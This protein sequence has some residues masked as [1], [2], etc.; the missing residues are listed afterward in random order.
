MVEGNIEK[1]A[2]LLDENITFE[3]IRR[4]HEARIKSFA[5]IREAESF[6]ANQ[7]FRALEAAVC[8]RMYDDRLNWLTSRACPGTA[9]WLK[10]DEA[11]RDWLDWSSPSTSLL[12]VHGIPGAGESHHDQRALQPRQA[13]LT[14]ALTGK[15]F[16]ACWAVAEAK[17]KGRTLYAFPSH[18]HADT[19]AL[20]IL[21]TL[22]FQSASNDGHLQAMVSDSNKR[23]LMSD[24]AVAKDLLADVLK[25]AGDTFVVVDGVDELEEF[26]RKQLL[27]S[28]LDILGAC[29]ESGL[30][31]YISS[32]EE[33]DVRRILH[34]KAKT[35][36]V[37]TSNRVAINTYVN[38]R[39]DEWMANSEFLDQGKSEIR[40]LLYPVCLKAKGT[41]HYMFFFA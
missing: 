1:H 5:E 3:H 10:K 19:T 16:L 31:I 34:P 36:C 33:D 20:S 21:L 13:F 14:S 9:E 6:R 17:K 38:S 39:F 7:R 11:F 8:P 15:T 26:E 32:R 25:C 41:L 35:I 2:K 27:R 24:A 40:A 18:I 23:D 29:R 37:Q 22:L 12:W 30:K 4:E 28:L